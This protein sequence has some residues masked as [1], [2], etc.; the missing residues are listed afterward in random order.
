MKKWQKTT[1]L[2]NYIVATETYANG[3]HGSV[4]LIENNIVIKR[5]EPVEKENDYRGKNLEILKLCIKLPFFGN[6]WIVSVYNSPGKPLSLEKAFL[7]RMSNVFVCG[8]F[9]SPHQELNRSYDS[10][11]GEKLL[12]LIEKGHFK[13]LNNGHYTYQSVDGKSRTMLDL[14]FCDSTVF[15]NF[16]NFEISE[17]LGSDHRTTITT[18]NLKISKM[19]ELKSKIDLRIFKENTRKSYRSSILWP[20]QYPGKDYLNQFSSSLVELIHKSL[21]DFYVIKNK[22]PYSIETRKLIKLKR[23]KQRQLKSAFREDFRSLKTEINYLQKE[24]K[25]SIRQSEERK[26][27]KISE[28]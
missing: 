28:R 26:R 27:A 10:E 4:I 2:S 3:H 19:F 21:E 8:D 17:D 20:A 18:L 9:N 23:R 7:E 25:R 15:T 1:P 14:H 11:N 6:F 12:N 24:I 16:N 13:W 22:F 5:G